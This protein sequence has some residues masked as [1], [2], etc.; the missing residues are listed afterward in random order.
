MRQAFKSNRDKPMGMD[1]CGRRP[2]SEVGEYFRANVWSWRPIHDLMCRLCADLLSEKVLTGMGY[3]DGAGPR[4][5]KVC[6]EMAKRFEQWLEQHTE[7]HSVDLGMRVT[8]GGKLSLTNKQKHAKGETPH[9]V[10][11]EHLKEWV[12]F[13][14]NC[15]GFEVW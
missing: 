11:D 12:E 4:G 10:D 8:K 9:R 3:N 13:L 14:R 6:T 5:Q 1:V 15:G 7:G 2:K